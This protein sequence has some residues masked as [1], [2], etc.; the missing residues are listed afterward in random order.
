[1]KRYNLSEI[2]RHAWRLFRRLDNE[3]RKITRYQESHPLFFKLKDAY[4]TIVNYPELLKIKCKVANVT[5]IQ[6]N[7]LFGQSSYF[8][9]ENG[10]LWR[11]QLL[12]MYYDR[13]E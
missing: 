2:M 9:D 5:K 13:V 8:E 4:K 12:D 6:D 1:M 7:E 10:V 11:Q 3:K